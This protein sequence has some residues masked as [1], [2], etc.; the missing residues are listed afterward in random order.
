MAQYT[1]PAPRLHLVMS[2]TYRNVPEEWSTRFHFKGPAPA[3]D[4][5]WLALSDKVITALKPCFSA[6]TTFVRAYGY[7]PNS[8]GATWV[9]DY[10]VPGPPQ[11]GTGTFTNGGTPP[12]DAAAVL[13]LTLAKMSLRGKH[14]YKRNYVHG[15]ATASVSAGDQLHPTQ[16]A[17]FTTFL[18]SYAQGTIDPA[19]DA[20]GPDLTDASSP[21][22]DQWITTRTLKRRGKRKINTP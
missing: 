9:H 21:H 1:Q 5:N 6:G 19:F 14:V 2:F 18:T 8:V 22:V 15:I 4:T 11:A 17:A 12:G 3:N 7:L 13:R 10:T 20:C 16:Q